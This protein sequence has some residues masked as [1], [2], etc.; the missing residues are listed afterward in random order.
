MTK[1]LSRQQ[2]TTHVASLCP[3]EFVLP[4]WGRIN[5]SNM[6]P[7]LVWIDSWAPCLQMLGHSYY[8]TFIN[9]MKQSL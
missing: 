1:F 2:E 8:K 7:G 9:N 6:H 4:S 5:E 3:N